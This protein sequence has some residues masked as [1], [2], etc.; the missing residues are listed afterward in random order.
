MLIVVIV[1]LAC[2]DTAE[3]KVNITPLTNVAFY[4]LFLWAMSA[5]ALAN[6]TAIPE[7]LLAETYKKS[8]DIS[9]YL[10]SEKLDGVRAYWDGKHLISRQ[11]N[12]F[13]APVW[14]T[15]NFPKQPLDGELWIARHHFQQTVSTVRKHQPIDQEWRKITYQLFELPQAKGTFQQRVEAME[16][17]VKHLAIPHLK[18]IKQYR[19]QTSDELNKKLDSVVAQGAEGLMLHRAN[20]R[21]LTGRSHALLKVKR[22]QDAEARVI[23]HLAGKGKFTDM[24]G[25]I[26]VEDQNGLKFKIGTGFTLQQRKNPPNIGS[27]ITYKYFGKTRKGLPRFASFL[28]LR[29][30]PQLREQN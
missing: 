14:F 6:Q 9:E 23:Q 13:Y 10:V 16:Q 27:I 5:N 20:A 4:C 30:L 8:I 18:V 24:L 7:L 3:N 17:L 28:R 29:T 26:L 1:R 2:R 19:L 22:Y 15:E 21:Y 11:G 12:R 25:S